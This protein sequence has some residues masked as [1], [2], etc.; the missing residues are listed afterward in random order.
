MFSL[1]A[2]RLAPACED[3]VLAIRERKEGG[4]IVLVADVRDGADLAV[5][6]DLELQNMTANQ[7]MH[8]TVDLSWQPSADLVTIQQG[9]GGAW[10]YR[11]HYNWR[12][13][14][15]GGQPDESVIYELPYAPPSFFELQ[16]GNFGK[17]SHYAGSFNEHAYDFRM[18]VGTLVRAARAGVVAGTRADS[19]VSG[20]N[21]AFKQC[22]N[23][24]IVRHADGT[25]AEYLHLSTGGVLVKV[26]DAVT[27]GQPLAR[28]GNIGYSTN[29]HLH[30][31]VF[32]VI[33]GTRRE[34]LPVRF[35]TRAGA[36]DAL[37]E[38]R[39]Y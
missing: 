20:A 26:G 2:A 29:P 18:P 9:N 15:R 33:D 34:T 19:T 17:F 28:S 10:R 37:R 3:R 32:R 31:C 21:P 5:T 16:Q 24:V 1:G 7:P 35:H 38:G 25:Y 39:S 27:V 4:A 13:G 14:R 36:V 8:F 12:Y 23:Y 11:Y 30:F 22:A 6:V